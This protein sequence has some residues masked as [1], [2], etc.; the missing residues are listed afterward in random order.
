[1]NAQKK[2]YIITYSLKIQSP[3]TFLLLGMTTMN[4]LLNK[5]HDY[6]SEVFSSVPQVSKIL[7]AKNFPPQFS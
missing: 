2:M 6:W 3:N 1:M 5:F 7:E 4:V